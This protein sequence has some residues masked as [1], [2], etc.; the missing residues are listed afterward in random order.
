MNYY[1]DKIVHIVKS[2]ILM[3]VK[4]QYKVKNKK[5]KRKKNLKKDFK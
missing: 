4:N 1:F 3:P 2:K 5:I